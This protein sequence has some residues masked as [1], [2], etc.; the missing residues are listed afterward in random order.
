[1]RTCWSPATAASILYRNKGDGTFEDVTAKAGLAVPG[2]SIGA[3]WLDYDRDGC[4]GSVRRPVRE[5][6]PGV[7]RLLRRRQLSRA[8]RLRAANQRAV[9]QQLQRRL[10][11][12]ER[13]KPESPVSR[14]APWASPPRISTST[15]IPISTSPTTRARTSCSTTSERDLRG[16]RH[17]RPAWHSDKTAR[18]RRRWDRFSPT[19]TATASRSLGFRLEV[20]PPV[21]N[22]GT[23]SSTTSPNAP[24]SLNLRPSTSVGEP[25]SRISTTTDGDDIFIVHG[26]L[27]H[28]VPQEHAIFRNLGGRKFEDVH[29]DRRPL[30]RREERRPRRRLRRLR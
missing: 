9:A 7:S 20:Q 1:M 25:A 30:L 17:P 13:D 28:M 24:E 4:V 14:A 2:W 15:A 19:S 27:V 6:R 23:D 5:V 18:T 11:R 26:G 22:T 21:K 29:R 8:A 3:A 12:C 10:H 16:D